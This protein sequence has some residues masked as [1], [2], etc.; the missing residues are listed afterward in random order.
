LCAEVHERDPQRLLAR[1]LREHA[2]II[3]FIGALDD[4]LEL[5]EEDCCLGSCF[6]TIAYSTVYVCAQQPH[7]CDEL[8]CA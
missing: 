2:Q 5:E 3:A 4:S 1:F 7:L 8:I 6:W